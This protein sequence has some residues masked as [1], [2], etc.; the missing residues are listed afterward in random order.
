RALKQLDGSCIPTARLTGFLA[1]ERGPHHQAAG[2]ESGDLKQLVRIA[3]EAELGCRRSVRSTAVLDGEPK[4][5]GA[6]NEIVPEGDGVAHQRAIREAPGAVF[7]PM[8]EYPGRQTNR[9]H[10]EQ[11]P[12]AREGA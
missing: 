1:L 5:L 3:E 8:H 11:H 2:E 6:E 9:E 4:V 7:H 10:L 12:A